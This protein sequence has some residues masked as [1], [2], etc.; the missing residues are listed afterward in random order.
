MLNDVDSACAAAGGDLAIYWEYAAEIERSSP[1]TLE[2]AAALGLTP[3][4]VDALFIAAAAI[5]G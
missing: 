1:R 3:A 5:T 2:L 4:Q